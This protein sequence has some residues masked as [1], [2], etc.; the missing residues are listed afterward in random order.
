MG[1]HVTVRSRDSRVIAPSRAL[2][3]AA[4][5]A[6]RRIAAAEE[7]LAFAIVDS[8]IHLLLL[9]SRDRAGQIARALEISISRQSKAAVAF[10]P[11][12]F[13]PIADQS[14]LQAAFFYVLDQIRHH[15]ITSD[16]THEGTVAQDLLGLRHLEPNVVTLVRERLPRLTRAQILRAANLPE[17]EERVELDVLVDA[18]A[19]AFALA[20]L[21]GRADVTARARMAAVHAAPGVSVALLASTLDVD[22]HSIRRMRREKSDVL[23]TLAVRRQIGLRHAVA[24]LGPVGG[25]E[26]WVAESAGTVYDRGNVGATAGFL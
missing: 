18:A 13:K 25:E 22:A 8:H 5:R 6:L 10:D 26:G 7:L 15:K 9:C 23:D 16:P 24:T 14:H 11:A 17:F 19:A 20:D 2:R 3:R 12:R 21:G 1:W 4:V